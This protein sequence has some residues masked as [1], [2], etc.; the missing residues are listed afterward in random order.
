M[1]I[2]EL[3]KKDGIERKGKFF[4]S[5]NFYPYSI[6]YTWEDEVDWSLYLIQFLGLNQE[7]LEEDVKEVFEFDFD[8]IVDMYLKDLEEEK[9]KVLKPIA[10][11]LFENDLEFLKNYA[12]ENNMKYQT[13]IRDFVHKWTLELQKN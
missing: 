6:K 1:F 10:V 13:L 4:K 7:F 12:S 5:G 9:K 8:E 2:E 3:L 11:R